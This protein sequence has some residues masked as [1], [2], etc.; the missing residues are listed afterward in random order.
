MQDELEAIVLDLVNDR[1]AAIPTAQLKINVFISVETRKGIP[2]SFRNIFL[3][4]AIEA[5]DAMFSQKAKTVS[6]ICSFCMY[7]NFNL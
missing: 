4:K 5:L 7:T 3:T 1:V 2:D 6:I